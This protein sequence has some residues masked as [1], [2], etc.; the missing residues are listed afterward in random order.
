MKR[1]RKIHLLKIITIV[2]FFLFFIPT[3]FFCFLN[4]YYQDKIFPGVRAASINLGGKKPED[5]LRVLEEEKEKFSVELLPFSLSTAL[6]AAN[7]CPR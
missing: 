4:F 6:I 3:L 5:A 7:K 1:E 2:S